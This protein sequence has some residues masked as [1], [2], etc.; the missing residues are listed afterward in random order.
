MVPP[1]VGGP[2]YHNR[3][4][5]NYF[6]QLVPTETA[7]EPSL[8]ALV[9]VL[10]GVLATEIAARGMPEPVA[11]QLVDYWCRLLEMWTREALDQMRAPR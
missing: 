1:F 2:V 3:D 11:A 7:L 9:R 10:A 5:L 4:K 6:D 8:C